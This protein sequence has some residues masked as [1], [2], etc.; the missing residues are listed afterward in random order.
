M[1]E[2]VQMVEN[3]WDI[4]NEVICEYSDDDFGVGEDSEDSENE[5]EC[6]AGIENVCEATTA[7]RDGGEIDW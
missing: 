6:E 4:G 3:E 1:N 2:I 7:P 5:G